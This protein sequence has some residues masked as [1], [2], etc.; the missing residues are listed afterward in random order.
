MGW[1]VRGGKRYY[2]RKERDPRTGRVRSRYCGSGAKGE[3]A[4]REDE[5]R[6]AA[7]VA[8]PEAANIRTL[9]KAANSSILEKPSTSE[10]GDLIKPSIRES[11]RLEKV[12]NE[13]V[14]KS[15]NP[16]GGGDEKPSIAFHSVTSEMRHSVTVPVDVAQAEVTNVQQSE[17]A[18]NDRKLQEVE[19]LLAQKQGVQLVMKCLD[20]EVQD[21]LRDASNRALYLRVAAFQP[22]I[23]RLVYP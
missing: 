16:D 9:K 21:L 5:E 22:A 19:Q 4:A 1:E 8:Q 15:G 2:Y 3:Q 17:R 14:V 20:R 6:R 7:P 13:S 23:R 10:A 11:E 18:E 12:S